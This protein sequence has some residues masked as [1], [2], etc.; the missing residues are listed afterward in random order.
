MPGYVLPL[1]HQYTHTN[2]T[3]KVGSN[4]CFQAIWIYRNYH[5]VFMIVLKYLI[6]GP[7]MPE[8]II[9]LYTNITLY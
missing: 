4:H 3:A 1:Q 5:T 8:C 7:K 6:L 2:W 9:D